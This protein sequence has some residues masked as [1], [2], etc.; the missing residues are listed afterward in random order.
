M[1]PIS[2]H[3][4]HSKDFCDHA[5]DDKQTLIQSYLANGFE[6][7]AITEHL[8][9][10]NDSFLYPDERDFGHD[11][12][13]LCER[14]ENYFQRTVPQLR[15]ELQLSPNYLFGFE[16][17]YYGPNPLER[18]DRAVERFQPELIVAS[19]HHVDDI[20]IDYNEE[21]YSKAVSRAG[22]I[23]ALYMKYYDH[24]LSVIEHMA[25][26]TASIPIVLGHMDLIKLHSPCHLISEDVLRCIRRNITAACKANIAIEVN[27]RAFS[28]GLNEP[29]PS[30][31]L[32]EE[33]ETAGAIL[34]IGDDAHAGSEVARDYDKLIELFQGPFCI[35]AKDSESYHWQEY[36]Q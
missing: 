1:I 2:Y 19:V 26:Y 4:G 16:T 24:Q 9:P 17:E 12:A 35:V 20:P 33:I 27:A 30:P 36:S 18:I 22:G 25:K 8:P 21:L 13:F 6:Y 32:I 31:L 5:H 34:T 7:V 29:Y 15:K 10:E 28:K 11:A 23:D 3:G 14:F